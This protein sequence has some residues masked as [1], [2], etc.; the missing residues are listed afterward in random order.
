MDRVIKK[1][2]NQVGRL[3]RCLPETRKAILHGLNEELQELPPVHTSSIQAL[4]AHY[5]SILQ[6]ADELQDSVPLEE[7]ARH[8]KTQRF[9]LAITGTLCAVLAAVTLYVGIQFGPTFMVLKKLADYNN[10]SI[11]YY[12]EVAPLY[13]TTTIEVWP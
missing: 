4:E 5:G 10:V 6:T 7:Q 9:K 2:C 8:L 3:L 1:Y 12:L 13:Y 11:P